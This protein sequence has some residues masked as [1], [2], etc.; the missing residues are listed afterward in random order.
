MIDSSRREKR[1]V[2]HAGGLHIRTIYWKLRS[3][4]VL[5]IVSRRVSTNARRHGSRQGPHRRQVA[6]KVLA[7]HGHVHALVTI[8]DFIQI[9]MP[10]QSHGRSGLMQVV[11]H[12]RR[13]T[14][15]GEGDKNAVFLQGLRGLLEQGL[16]FG[17]LLKHG[18]VLQMS[19]FLYSLFG[20]VIVGKGQCTTSFFVIVVFHIHSS[21]VILIE[22]IKR[23]KNIFAN[24]VSSKDGVHQTRV[25]DTIVAKC[26]LGCNTSHNWIIFYLLLIFR[27]PR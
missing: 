20:R 6:G 22:N 19:S 23:R 15:R 27:H 8:V 3:Q 13:R 12:G 5:P 26:S 18:Q 21:I 25:K 1:L 7:R 17:K 2:N 4:E 11:T 16:D 24:I 10:L 9:K 14:V